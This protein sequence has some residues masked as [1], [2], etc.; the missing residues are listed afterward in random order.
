MS[1]EVKF[2]YANGLEIQAGSFDITMKFLRLGA[3]TKLTPPGQKLV[4]AGQAP[5]EIFDS[6]SVTMSPSH[7][8]IALSSLMRGILNYENSSGAKIQMQPEM[9]SLFNDAVNAWKAANP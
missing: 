2:F 3:K 8:K 6:L 4:V 1:D 5:P 7:A 9:E